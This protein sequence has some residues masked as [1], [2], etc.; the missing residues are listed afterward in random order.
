MIEF[1]APL[2]AQAIRLSVAEQNTRAGR[3]I[4]FTASALKGRSNTGRL[5]AQGARRPFMV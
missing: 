5:L 4:I 2:G 3:Q 1:S